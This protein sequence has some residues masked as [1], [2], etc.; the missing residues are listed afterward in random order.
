MSMS[1]KRKITRHVRPAPTP[2]AGS[3]TATATRERFVRR[4]RRRGVAI[5]LFVLSPVIA[6][7]HILEHLGKFQLMSPAAEDLFIGWPMAFVL[8]I[9]GGILWG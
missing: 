3:R 1:P 6:I 7:T 4:R 8:L 2:A 5:G 9:V